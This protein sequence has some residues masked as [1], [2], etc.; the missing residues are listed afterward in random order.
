M[1]ETLG[2]LDLSKVKENKIIKCEA[3][4]YYYLANLKAW[5]EM[6]VKCEGV[7]GEGQIS[8]SYNVIL[9]T[10]HKASP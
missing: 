1:F 10:R 5:S 6:R 3:V 8:N 7:G 2:T 4:L 9:I